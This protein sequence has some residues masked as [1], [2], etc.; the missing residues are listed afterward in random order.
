LTLEGRD[1]LELNLGVRAMCPSYPI[2]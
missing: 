2:R 1:M